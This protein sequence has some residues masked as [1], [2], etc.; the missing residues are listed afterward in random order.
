MKPQMESVWSSGQQ[1]ESPCPLPRRLKCRCTSH[2]LWPLCVQ[3]TECLFFPLTPGKETAR[4]GCGAGGVLQPGSR[5]ARHMCKGP[6]RPGSSCVRS[7]TSMPL[8]LASAFCSL[9]SSSIHANE[10]LSLSW[11]PAAAEDAPSM[12]ERGGNN[13][14]E[15]LEHYAWKERIAWVITAAQA[16]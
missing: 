8:D 10:T 12:L 14:D 7:W 2:A 5:P 11:L 6:R 9:H 16:G 13:G 4:V 15:A 1:Q 3:H